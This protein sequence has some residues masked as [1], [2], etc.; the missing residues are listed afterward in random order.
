MTK[1]SQ[2]RNNLARA[3][4]L[5]SRLAERPDLPRTVRQSCS[6]SAHDLAAVKYELNPAYDKAA[7]K[8]RAEG[9]EGTKAESNDWTYG[10]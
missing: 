4:T 1:S 2:T 7:Q 6:R 10:G 3:G 9:L 5:L 8:L